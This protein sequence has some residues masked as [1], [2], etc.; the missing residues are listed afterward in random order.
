LNPKLIACWIALLLVVPE[1]PLDGQTTGSQGLQSVTPAGRSE[2]GWLHRFFAGNLNRDLWELP[3]DVPTLDLGSYAGGLT[4]IQRGGGLQTKSLRL[5]GADGQVYNFRSVDKDATVSLDPL[6]RESIVA[7]VMQDQTAALFPLSARVVS[8][9]LDATDLLHADPELFVLPSDPRLGEFQEE[10]SGVLG[11]VEVRPDEGPDGE[12]GFAGSTRVTG[13]EAFLERL[14]ESPANRVDDEAFLRAR[15]MDLFVGDWDRHPDQWRWAEFEEDGGTRWQPIP[16]DRDWALARL[17]GIGPGIARQ[18]WMNYV[19][20]SE[21][22]ES[23]AGTVWNGRALDR[24]LL[25]ELNRDDW[26]R[27][28]ED[29]RGLLSN[30]VITD[31]VATLPDSYQAVVG[32]EL[33][34]ALLSR[35]DGLL[36]AAMDYYA[37]LAGWVDIWATDTDEQVRVDVLEAGRLRV[38]V[39]EL[40]DDGAE[41]A[42]PF[43][44]RVF[45]PDETEEVRLYLRGGDDHA[46]VSG[47]PRPEIQVRVVGGGGDDSFEDRTEGNGVHYYDDRGDNIVESGPSTSVDFSDWEE[48]EDTESAT[49]GARARDWGSRWRG[50][51]LFGANSD[52]GFFVG[53][54][55]SRETYEFR[56]FPKATLLTYD[57]AVNPIEM[58][59]AGEVGYEFPLGGGEWF[60]IARMEGSTRRVGHYYGL[61]NGTTRQDEE[62]EFFRADRAILKASLEAEYRIRSNLS[63]G[64]GTFATVSRATDEEGTFIEAEPTHGF[65]DYSSAGALGRLSLDWRDNPGSPRT[66]GLI[67]LEGRYTPTILDVEDAFGSVAAE[68]SINVPLGLP[69]LSLRAGGEKVWGTFPYFDGAALGGATTLRGFTADRFRGDAS[70]LASAAI[71][72]PIAEFPLVLPAVL[73]VQAMIDGGR[74]FLEDDSSLPATGDDNDQ[75]HSGAGGGIW[76]SFSEGTR[77]LAISAMNSDEGTR[78]YFSF[79]FGY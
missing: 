54:R 1:S 42:Q 40:D 11:W 48:P 75:W 12:P 69:T 79:G 3:V 20:F 58:G 66:G 74:V 27:V 50:F 73:G 15:L 35:R 26:I 31:A 70:V 56:R 21:D 16:R 77:V 10:F 41:P 19:G 18:V 44:E 46:L 14:E 2:A 6:I 52:I 60:G 78:L 62:E 76:I 43:F 38:R 17:D 5:Q 7:S 47:S 59:V 68:A 51:T 8:R 32:A 67:E 63:V 22:Y 64:V 34:E 33:T 24:E 29:L 28:A 9:L 4:V 53:R 37:I 65:E 55:S 30:E 71:R 57:I 36:V 49:H 39:F 72:A 45:D 23:V 61:G 25:S 13:T